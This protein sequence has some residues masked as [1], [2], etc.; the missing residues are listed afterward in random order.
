MKLHSADGV[1]MSIILK[2]KAFLAT[3][4]VATTVVQ[5]SLASNLEPKDASFACD[6]KFAGGI[7][8]NEMSKRWDSAQFLPVP[9][10][11]FVLNLQF[12]SIDFRKDGRGEDEPVLS[13]RVAIAGERNGY[14]HAPWFPGECKANINVRPDA[15]WFTCSSGVSNYS[16]NLGLGRFIASY[17]AG[18]VNGSDNNDDMPSIS[19]GICYKL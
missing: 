18:Y 4:A 1:A 10:R 17:M 12:V 15:P 6:V 14:P 3:L 5:P 2:M 13:F 19:G 8:V 9:I 11:R 7:A 16:V